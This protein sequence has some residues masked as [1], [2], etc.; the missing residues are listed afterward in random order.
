MLTRGPRLS[1][2]LIA[3]GLAIGLAPLVAAGQAPTAPPTAL[4]VHSAIPSQEAATTGFSDPNVPK[5]ASL[6]PPPSNSGPDIVP[7]P[8][9]GL[10]QPSGPVWPPVDP[11][12]APLFSLKPTYI[13]KGAKSGSFQGAL[14]RAT[15]LPRFGDGGFGMTDVSQQL[16]FAVPPFISGSPFLI[17]PSATVHF[18]D[19][20][21]GVD[22]PSRLYDFELEFRYM[23]MLTG[24]W[25]LDAA[26]AP[27][28]FGDLNNDSS[29]A[30]RL[31]GR[32]L[33][34]WDW[35]PTVKL[36]GG[37]L[38]LGRED[39]PV[40]PVGGLIWKPNLT[41]RVD[42]V[43]PR[44]RVYYL[45]SACGDMEQRVY[46]GGEFGGNT[47]AIDRT[48]DI[49]DKFTYS[50]LRLVL[51][52]ERFVPGGFNARAEI[53]WVFDRDIEFESGIPGTT[54]DNTM[55]VRGEFNF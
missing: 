5:V 54:P 39:Y 38:F 33:T 55:M 11:E 50:D 23:K 40:L 34:A 10:P 45:V 51:G 9:L 21:A 12:P 25:G 53:G 7:L 35:T 48:G 20:P 4:P 2:L 28:Y 26:I 30:W 6:L 36:V 14:S 32:V 1:L 37:M 19:G 29:D 27:S 49:P 17:T 13:P 16:T 43:F 3:G 18:L 8:P 41:W 47:W 22:L 46:L 52:W 15:Y 44:P 31:T 42:A 24:R